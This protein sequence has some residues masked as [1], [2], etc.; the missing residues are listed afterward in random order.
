MSDAFLF[1]YK[2]SKDELPGG[3]AKSFNWDLIKNI[4]TNKPWF[5]SGGININNINNINKYAIPYGIDISS[6]VEVK[7]GIKSLKKIKSLVKFYETK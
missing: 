7:P 5:L 3:N 4:K 1:D 6:G 2:P